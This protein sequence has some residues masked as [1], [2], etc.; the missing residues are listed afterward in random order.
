MP[1][2][3]WVI[4]WKENHELIGTINLGNVEESC[5]MSDTNREMFGAEK[6]TDY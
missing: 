2:L 3:K 1:V 4:E 5:F 6:D